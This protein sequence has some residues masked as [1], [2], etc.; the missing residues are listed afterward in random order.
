LRVVL[1]AMAETI[2]IQEDLLGLD[3]QLTGGFKMW[4]KKKAERMSSKQKID[5]LA[6]DVQSLFEK[7]K[8]IECNHPIVSRVSSIVYGS[9]LY[10]FHGEECEACSLCGK[11]IKWD[12][13]PTT[14]ERKVLKAKLKELDK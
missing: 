10:T 11:V 8:Q 9:G 14:V 7:V 6:R 1:Q 3:E 13:N 12:I 5:S 2:I 4:Y